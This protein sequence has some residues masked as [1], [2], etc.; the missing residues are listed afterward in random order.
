MLFL[1]NKEFQDQT[2]LL[3]IDEIPNPMEVL[4][5]TL[6]EI[7]LGELRDIISKAMEVCLTTTNQAFA[8]P[9][10]RYELLSTFRKIELLIEA[11]SLLY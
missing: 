1:Q 9:V 8:T 7:K 3:S 5:G 4:K 10:G 2:I 6:N 11:A